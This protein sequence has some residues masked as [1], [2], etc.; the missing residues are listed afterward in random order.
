VKRT[1]TGLTTPTA[2]YTAVQQVT[3]FGSAQSSVLVNVY[4]L[5]TLVGRGFV[6]V[7]T[8]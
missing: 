7:A 4:Q 1:I 8:I 5:S 6:G 2:S 3:D